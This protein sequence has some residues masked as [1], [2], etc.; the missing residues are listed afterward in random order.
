MKPRWRVPLPS[1]ASLGLGGLLVLLVALLAGKGQ[2][3]NFFSLG[4]LQLL[5]HQAAIPAV[6]ALGMLLVIISGGIDL[7]VG[8]VVA[9]A[10]V[11]TMQA[12]QAVLDRTGSM[13]F[14]S[15]AAVGAGV[16]TGGA[17][18]LING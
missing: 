8:S 17:C 6:V 7:S 11:S 14:A 2:F 12:Y 4:N 15:L 3:F 1:G 9:L 10:S 5:L 16:G 18:G 13:A